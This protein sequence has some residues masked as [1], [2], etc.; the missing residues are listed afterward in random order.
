MSKHVM[1]MLEGESGTNRGLGEAGAV[2][3]TLGQLDSLLSARSVARTLDV[4]TRC[5]RRWVSAGR[6]PRADVRIGTTLRWRTSTVSEAI[7]R[8]VAEA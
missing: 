6:F 3:E 5:L 1:S 2:S 8:M 7:A 4:S